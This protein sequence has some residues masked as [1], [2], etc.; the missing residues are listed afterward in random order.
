MVK[1][2]LKFKVLFCSLIYWFSFLAFSASFADPASVG[3]SGNFKIIDSLPYGP[4]RC[5]VVKDDFAFAANG[6]VIL[7]YD[8]GNMAV[9]EKMAEIRTIGIIMKMVVRENYLYAAAG[10]DG[11]YVF[12]IKD[13]RKPKMV[14]HLPFKKWCSSIFISAD[15]LFLGQESSLKVFKINNSNP[16]DIY[17]INELFTQGQVENFLLKDNLLFVSCRSDGFY[18]FDLK[19]NF[20]TVQH[21]SKRG[22]VAYALADFQEVVY[23]NLGEWIYALDTKSFSYKKVVSLPT[24]NKIYF[25]LI[26]EN[27]AYVAFDQQIYCFQ[28]VSPFSFRYKGKKYLPSDHVR[29]AVLYKN[30]MY[31]SAEDAGL[32]IFDLSN[33]EDLILKVQIDSPGEISGAV[34]DKDRLLVTDY[35]GLS[36]F[37]IEKSL[38]LESSGKFFMPYPGILKAR[39]HQ[40]YIFILHEHPDGGP[41]FVEILE[42]PGFN[43]IQSIKFLEEIYDIQIHNNKLFVI[44]EHR[45]YI[46]DIKTIQA[47][48]LEYKVFLPSFLRSVNFFQNTIF[49]TEYKVQDAEPGMLA[50]NLVDDAAGAKRY[51]ITQVTT[52]PLGVYAGR[53]MEAD[54]FDKLFEYGNYIY[55]T[56]NR[57]LYVFLKNNNNLEFLYSVILP[58]TVRD[59]SVKQK[60]NINYLYLALEDAGLCVIKHD[61][62]Q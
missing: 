12:D 7:I 38:K 54:Y 51:F 52:N 24:T 56:K 31:A 16:T 53:V 33:P 26:R 35:K 18:I 62:F 3:N 21:I 58:D 1:N 39:I 30:Y 48:K 17:L 36:I 34:V 8:V 59:F 47:P 28:I 6:G 61:M 5:V 14:I 23:F 49:V 55:V 41:A 20:K 57:I 44:S 29:Q 11:M 37:N 2:N 50:F 32:M 4:S 42:M 9:P 40:N 25:I 13:H 15:L 10:S 46:Y 45:F 27:Y 43:K 22:K 60:E 19:N